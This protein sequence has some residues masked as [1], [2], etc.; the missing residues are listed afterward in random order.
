MIPLYVWTVICKLRTNTPKATAHKILSGTTQLMLLLQ[1]NSYTIW[2]KIFVTIVFLLLSKST[3]TS[4]KCTRTP[5][6]IWCTGN[7]FSWY[8]VTCSWSLTLR[9]LKFTTW[10]LHLFLSCLKPV[11]TLFW[12][13]W[14][15]HLTRVPGFQSVQTNFSTGDCMLPLLN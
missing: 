6:N 15:V 5:T 9:H 1:G 11:S 8:Q 3:F 7:T 12:V 13:T 10:L 2:Y 14:S 4:S